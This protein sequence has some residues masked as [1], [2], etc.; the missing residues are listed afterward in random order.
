M[1]DA[2]RA[3][4]LQPYVAEQ[5]QPARYDYILTAHGVPDQT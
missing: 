3:E 1:L 5:L 2:A 4:R